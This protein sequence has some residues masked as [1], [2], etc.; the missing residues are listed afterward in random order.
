MLLPELHSWQL[1]RGSLCLPRTPADPL[2]PTPA[3]RRTPA[4]RSAGVA[5][6]SRTP[7]SSLTSSPPARWS[8]HSSPQPSAV[9]HGHS[10]YWWVVFY[11]P[12]HRVVSACSL[13]TQSISQWIEPKVSKSKGCKL[14]D[15]RAGRWLK[16]VMC[17][18]PWPHM[19]HLFGKPHGKSLSPPQPISPGVS[20]P[21]QDPCMAL[22]CP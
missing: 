9:T 19:T 3:E 20:P 4:V 12:R 8:S 13:I 21:P 18:S 2:P 1:M 6:G 15:F 5:T 16:G 22:L 7:L 10:T 11:S 17:A 14:H